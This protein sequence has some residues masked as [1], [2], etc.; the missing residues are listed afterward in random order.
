MLFNILTQNE[1]VLR[2]EENASNCL[3]FNQEDWR[4]TVNLPPVLFVAIS[5]KLGFGFKLF[6]KVDI[7]RIR[8]LAT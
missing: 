3:R 5:E 8:C 6:C 2:R 4:G 7:R 1:R